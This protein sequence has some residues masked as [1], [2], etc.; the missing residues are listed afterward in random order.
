[1]GLAGLLQ[2]G[3]HSGG[4]ESGRG[5]DA[6]GETPYAVRPAVSGR[7]SM[8]LAIWMAWLAAPLPRLSR[9]QTAI[10]RPACVS[11]ATCRWAALDPPV[12]PGLGQRPSPTPCTKG[13]PP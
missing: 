12:G 2:P 8:R 4:P 10:A 5:G 6:H 1:M 13:S 3:R 11:A 7:P 9:A